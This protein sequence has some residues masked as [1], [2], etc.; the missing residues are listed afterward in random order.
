M[1]KLTVKWDHPPLSNLFNFPP[2]N[3]I[4]R[5]T[6]PILVFQSH[7]PT[8][9]FLL[10]FLFL[11]APNPLPLFN[12]K[13]AASQ[14]KKG[15]NRSSFSVF[16]QRNMAQGIQTPHFTTPNLSKPHV[17]KASPHSLIFGSK[18]VNNSP[19]YL[20]ASNKE[21]IFT[22]ARTPLKVLASVATAEKPSAVPEIVLQ[23]IKEISGTVK[24]PGSKSLSN[25]IL[26]LAAL[27][28]VLRLHKDTFFM[29]HWER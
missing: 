5:K 18:V 11:S 13:V 14:L 17:L 29:I 24:L 23:P 21:S 3:P 27:S 25:R 9:F 7:L 22:K 16:C 4:E 26:L 28:E 15:G 2:P 20:R 8:P 12:R 10:L 1:K 19:K 6:Q